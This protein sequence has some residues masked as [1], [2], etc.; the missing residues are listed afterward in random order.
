MGVTVAVMRSTTS[1]SLGNWRPL[2]TWVPG[3]LD[4]V[5]ATATATATARVIATA[6]ASEVPVPAGALG[7][8]PPLYPGCSALSRRAFVSKYSQTSIQGQERRE[9]REL[10]KLGE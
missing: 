5:T 1:G 9:K 6:T 3:E 10:K 7:A 4:L 2:G 8:A